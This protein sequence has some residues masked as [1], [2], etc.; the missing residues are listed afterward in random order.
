[1]TGDDALPKLQDL[2]KQAEGI[3]LDIQIFRPMNKNER[4]KFYVIAHPDRCLNPV[5]GRDLSMQILD[6]AEREFNGPNAV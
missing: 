4:P 5:E 1:M 2:L 3:Q 6:A